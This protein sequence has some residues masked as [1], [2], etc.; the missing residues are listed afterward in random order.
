MLLIIDLKKDDWNANAKIG[1]LRSKIN[2]CIWWLDFFF[3]MRTKTKSKMRIHVCSYNMSY[4]NG[5]RLLYICCYK[6]LYMK[7]DHLVRVSNLRVTV[8]PIRDC[9]LLKI[10]TIVIFVWC[11]VWTVVREPYFFSCCLWNLF[12]CTHLIKSLITAEKY[13]ALWNTTLNSE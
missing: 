9:P 4:R 13:M 12:L 1:T 2:Y 6:I 11:L 8:V 5:L 7:E 10:N 3:E